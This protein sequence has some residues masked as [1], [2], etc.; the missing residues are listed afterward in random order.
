MLVSFD[1][2]VIRVVPRVERQEFVNAGVILY[3]AERQHL[4]A[5]L[6]LDEPRILALWPDTDLELVKQQLK[7][8]LDVSEGR[9]D[10]GPIARLSRSERFHWL[11]SPRSTIVQVSPVHSGLCEDPAV[12]MD[13]L[14]S[15]YC[16]I[17]AKQ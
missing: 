12:L 13:R 16:R 14:L 2:A 4:E 1:Y 9:P 3:S 17:P 10:A 6:C 11:T 8:L 5:Q 15:Q 7:A